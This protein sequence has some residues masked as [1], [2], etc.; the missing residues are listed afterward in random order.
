MGVA[1]SAVAYAL[2]LRIVMVPVA[3]IEGRAVSYYYPGAIYYVLWQVLWLAP[4][5]VALLVAA[6]LAFLARGRSRS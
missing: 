2:L 1:A 5:L 6:A 3:G 4:V